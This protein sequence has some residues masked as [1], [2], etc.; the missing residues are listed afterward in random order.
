MCG[1]GA[2]GTQTQSERSRGTSRSR[3]RPLVLTS[4][5]GASC[6]GAEVDIFQVWLGALKAGAWRR[7]AVD[8]RD[9]ASR[10]EL[11][12]DHRVVSFELRESFRRNHT[13]PDP[14]LELVDGARGLGFEQNLP[15]VDDGH[16]GAELAHVV[17][18]VRGK[19]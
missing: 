4:P 5:A 1:R 7:I 13:A 14:A 12:R 6:H 17:D 16:P 2:P 15:F 3:L 11:R 18:D 8:V 19:E 9:G 10:V